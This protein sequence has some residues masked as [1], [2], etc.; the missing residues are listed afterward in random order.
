MT[1]KLLL[2]FLL[3]YCFSTSVF[4]QQKD[5][6]YGNVKSVREQ[7]NFVDQNHQ[8]MKLFSSEGDYGHHGFS[9]AKFTKSRFNSWWYNTP[10]VHYINYYKEYDKDN[11]LLKEIWYYKNQRVL[12]SDEY[13]YNDLGKI[14]ERK[15]NDYKESKSTYNYDL[16]EN[17]IFIKTINTDSSFSTQKYKY[18][19]NGLVSES[20]H[21]DSDFPKEIIKSEKIYDSIG[22]IIEIKNYDE[23]GADYGTLFVYDNKNRK[24]KS[25]NH[26][27]FIWVKTKTG[28][29]QKRTDKGNNQISRE[30]VYDKKD[31]IIQAKYY[32]PDFDDNNTPALYKKVKYVYTNDLLTNQYF[33]DRNDSIT[34]FTKFEFDNKKRK[35]KESSIFPKYPKY[36]LIIEYSYD[37]NNI[38]PTKLIYSKEKQKAVVDFEHVFDKQNNWIKQV[39]SVNGK[40]LF[41][42]TREIKYY[43]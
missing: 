6:I 23:Y 11:R 30:F 27:P 31:R 29:K 4:S 16:N 13:T 36:N 37:E 35:T 1:N 34:S 43:E 40:K 2:T 42:W 9:S 33:Y 17:L 20:E 12:K 14:E 39:K 25:I 38:L 28:S 41:V 7:L 5:T 26:S 22:N 3:F 21:F 24:I 18:N 8:N 32:N 15:S 19:S 10:W